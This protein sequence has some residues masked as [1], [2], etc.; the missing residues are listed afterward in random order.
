MSCGLCGLS[1]L[2][3]VISSVEVLLLCVWVNT[4]LLRRWVSCA[5]SSALSGLVFICTSRVSAMLVVFV[6]NIVCAV[7]MLCSVCWL[8]LGVSSEVDFRNVAAVVSLL[9]WC[10]CVV[11]C[12]SLVVSVLLGFCVVCVRC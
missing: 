2:L 10:V 5:R 4:I 6:V 8:G 9:C 3:V 7:V 12:S 1:C 11:Q